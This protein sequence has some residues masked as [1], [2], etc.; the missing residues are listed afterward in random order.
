M[1]N[2]RNEKSNRETLD[3]GDCNFCYSKQTIFKE[4]G[5]RLSKNEVMMP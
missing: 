3:I 2:V 1:G 5:G 4:G